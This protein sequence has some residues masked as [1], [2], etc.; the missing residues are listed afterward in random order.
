[1]RWG[2]VVYVWLLDEAIGR[3][4]Q[5]LAGAKRCYSYLDAAAEG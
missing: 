2:V 1:M 3:Y 4:C 5:W